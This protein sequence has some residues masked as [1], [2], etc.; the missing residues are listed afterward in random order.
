M[1][2]FFCYGKDRKYQMLLVDFAILSRN[3]CIKVIIFI[4]YCVYVDFHIQCDIKPC[5]I[6]KRKTPED[7]DER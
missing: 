5:C 1:V 6:S 4:N 3:P 2:F 7:L